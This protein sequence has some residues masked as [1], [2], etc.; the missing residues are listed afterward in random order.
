[1][2]VWRDVFLAVIAV[3]T[4]AIAVA[5]IAV[6]VAA[7]AAAKRVGR[8]ADTFERE[9]KPL[10]GHLNA[11]GRDAARA[12][13][14]AS[15]QVERADRIFAETAERFEHA[16]AAIEASITAPAREGRAL[17]SAFRAAFQALRDI[18]RDGRPGRGDDEDALFI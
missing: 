18:R 1:V 11:I 10:V 2:I 15:A 9:M 3:A 5:Q 8:L 14:L 17:L 4:V 16:L 13:Q 12:A 6:I 7:A